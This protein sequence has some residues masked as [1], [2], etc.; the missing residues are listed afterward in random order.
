[1]S[2]SIFEHMKLTHRTFLCFA[3]LALSVS[4][5]KKDEPNNPAAFSDFPQL[6]EGLENQPA[7]SVYG[8]LLGTDEDGDVISF[9]MDENTLFEI[10]TDGSITNKEI[11][12]VDT[13]PNVLLETTLTVHVKDTKDEGR[14]EKPSSSAY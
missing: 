13:E 4:S 5:C 7:G 10:S 11:I 8:Q 6:I 3:F 12:D 2:G 9:S 14:D 1:M